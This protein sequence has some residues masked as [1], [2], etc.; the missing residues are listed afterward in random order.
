MGAVPLR[1]SF[2]A[3]RVW[4]DCLNT[5]LFSLLF[6]V[7]LSLEDLTSLRAWLGFGLL[8]GLTVLACPPILLVV[9]LLITRACY[10]IRKCGT[11]WGWSAGLAV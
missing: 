11:P 8:A 4:G 2:A 3:T 5:L 6:W 10:H 9:L 7:A 1:D